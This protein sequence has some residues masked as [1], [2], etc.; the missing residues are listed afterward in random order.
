MLRKSSFKFESALSEA[1]GRT[2]AVPSARVAVCLLPRC[3]AEGT[4]GV[5]KIRDFHL[6]GQLVEMDARE[7]YPLSCGSCPRI[8]AGAEAQG[9]YLSAGSSGQVTGRH[10]VTAACGRSR[11]HHRIIEEAV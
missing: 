9:M 7:G 4:V 3:L 6:G 5:G 11:H 1:A 8:G 10:R 2:P